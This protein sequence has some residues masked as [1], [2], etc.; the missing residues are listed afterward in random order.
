[1]RLLIFFAIGISKMTCLLAQTADTLFYSYVKQ[2]EIVGKQW[3]YQYGKNDYDYFYE[4]NDRGRG[5]AVKS[6]LQTDNKGVIIEADFK[7]IDYYKTE[8]NETFHIKDGKAYWKNQ[9][10]NDSAVF[11]NELYSDINGPIAEYQLILKML[12]GNPAGQVNVLPGGFRNF[13]QITSLDIRK[14]SIVHLNL[15]AFDGFGNGPYY[16]W[17]TKEGKFF[18]SLTP[19]WISLIQKGYEKYVDELYNI[20]RRFEKTYY[21]DLAS[22]LMEKPLSGLAIKNV[23]LFNPES[24][25]TLSDITVL[26][27]ENKIDKTGSSSEIKIPAGYKVIDGSGKFLMPGLWDMHCHY[28]KEM[29]P[30]LLA[31]GV[32]NVRDMGNGPELLITRRLTNEDSLLGPD[33]SVISGFIDKAGPM[34]GP[35]GVLVNNLKE[36]LQAVQDYKNKGYDQIKLYSSIEPAWVNPIAEKSHSLGMRV[37]GHVPAFMTASQAVNAG[38]DEITHINMLFLN[39]FGDTIDTRNMTRLTLP[40]EKGYTIDLQGEAVRQFI[41]QLKQHHTVL[42]PTLSAFEDNYVQMPGQMLKA[43][44]PISAYLPAEIHRSSLNGNYLGTPSQ[45]DIYAKSFQNMKGMVKEL[46]DSGLI[47]LAG[48]DGGI[49]QHELEL[50]STA[51]IPNAAVL[52]T[53]T[54]WPAKVAGM[55]NMFGT[56]YDGKTANLILVDGNPLKNIQDIRKIYLT[57]KEGKL[58][59]PKEIYAVYG[60]GYYY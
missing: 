29:G 46:Y 2:G 53:A 30:F 11:R 49:V 57:I 37:C 6:H 39:F 45:V 43:Y 35:T 4:F 56:I 16:F 25:K 23:T 3:E 5:P 26:I 33:I 27:R 1:M 34:A 40:G 44:L 24:G 32:T 20:Q 59:W 10:E 60:W 50:Y 54:Y 21:N 28:A 15:I 42:D 14:D 51:G 52:K 9:F 18:G 22:K 31:Q 47:V 58:Y 38:Y 8:V 13:K 12:Q 36:A 19:D 55:D 48:T 41:L 7:G 17:F